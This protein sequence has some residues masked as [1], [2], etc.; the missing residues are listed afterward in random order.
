MEDDPSVKEKDLPR[1]VRIRR[2]LERLGPAFIKMGQILATRR[3]LVTP[4]LAVELAKLQDDVPTMSWDE[5]R[6]RIES[7]LGGT[8]E[9]LFSEFDTTPLAAASI[10]QVYRAALPDGTVVAVKVQR[11]GVTETMEIDLEILVDRGGASRRTRSGARTSTR[12]R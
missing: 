3:D 9:E 7:E 1:A 11:P 4:D 5:M 8:V 2:A 12:R 6:V 10:G